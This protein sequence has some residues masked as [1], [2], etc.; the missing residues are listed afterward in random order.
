V[1]LSSTAKTEVV[2]RIKTILAS[3][4]LTLY[5]VSEKTRSLYGRSSPYFLPHNLYYEVGLGSFSPSLHQMFALS[6]ISNCRFNDWLSVFGFDPENV[7]RLQVLLSSKRTVLLDSSLEDPE[8]WVPWFRNRPGNLSDAAIGPIGRWLDRA[9]AERLRS[10]LPINTNDVIYAKVG[11]EDCLSFPDLLPG[12]IVR[13]N[14]RLAKSML[15]IESGKE[16]SSLFLIQHARGFCCCRLQAVSKHQVVPLSTQLPYAQ[17]QL[18]FPSEVTVLGVVDLEIRSLLKPEPPDVPTE[19]ARHWRPLKLWQ[20]G[21]KLSHLLRRARLRAGLSFREASA[22]SRRVASELGDK[23]YFAAP[24]SLS[25]YEATDTPPRHIHKAITLCAVYGLCFSM[26]LKSVGLPMDAAGEQPIPDRLVP[27]ECPNVRSDTE[28]TALPANGVFKT[29]LNR[30]GPPPFFLRKSVPAMSGLRVSSLNDFFWI[31]GEQNPLHPLL[32]N[33]IMAIVNRHR[34]RPF[35]FRSRPLWQQPVYVLLKRDGT[36]IGG[37]CSLE[38]GTLIV[39]PYS[40]STQ[41]PEHLRNHDDA[42][43]VGQVVTIARRL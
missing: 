34:K 13:A 11:S 40:P 23:Q 16:P 37:C 32:V 26:F 27:R 38:N 20:E 39:H 28:N 30:S 29:L 43:V 25:D 33:G 7:A 1:E 18:E 10:V 17:V 35:H 2:Q 5:Q 19:L 41:S 8:G 14:Q 31:G 6:K 24:G 42:E 36:Y 21:T 4:G 12:S 9:R 15:P 22:M 3:Q